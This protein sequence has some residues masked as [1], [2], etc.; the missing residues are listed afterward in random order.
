MAREFSAEFTQTYFMQNKIKQAL[1]D[2]ICFLLYTENA[3]F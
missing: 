3:A 2:M 1:S